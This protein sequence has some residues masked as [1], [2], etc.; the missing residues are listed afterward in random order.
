M[1][2]SAVHCVAVCCIVLQ[3]AVVCCSVLQCTAVCCDALQCVK[4][5]CSVLQCAAMCCSVLQTS[6][7]GPLGKNYRSPLLG[8]DQNRSEITFSKKQEQKY[9]CFKKMVCEY[10]Y[11]ALYL[12][13]IICIHT[14]I[15]V[16]KK[17]HSFLGQW[18]CHAALRS[19]YAYKGL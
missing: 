9:H 2:C 11:K 15:H 7:P 6:G 4:V 16:S 17:I 18:C 12:A 19:K 8:R 10:Y 5:C 3:C 1:C 14:K 13:V